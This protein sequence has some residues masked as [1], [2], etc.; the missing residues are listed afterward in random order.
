M[1]TPRPPDGCTLPDLARVLQHNTTDPCH[2]R[3]CDKGEGKL[4]GFTIPTGRRTV[5]ILGALRFARPLHSAFFRAM[6]GGCEDSPRKTRAA[7]SAENDEFLMT[8]D[9]SADRPRRMK[10][11]GHSSGRFGIGSFLRHSSLGIRHCRSAAKSF[12]PDVTELH[13]IA[14]AGKSEVP[15]RSATSDILLGLRHEFGDLADVR[16]HDAGAV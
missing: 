11:V 2:R 9:E 12:D 3:V 4:H 16:I 1:A 15:A 14:V 5:S 13:R 8:N 7:R 6:M 10:L